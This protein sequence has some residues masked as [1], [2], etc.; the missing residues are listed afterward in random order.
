MRLSL[1]F[2]GLSLC[3][4]GFAAQCSSYTIS[5]CANDCACQ[6]VSCCCGTGC[7]RPSGVVQYNQCVPANS[8]YEQWTGCPASN[9]CATNSGL[10]RTITPCVVPT[11]SPTPSPA[12]GTPDIPFGTTFPMIGTQ[13]L[14]H[15]TWQSNV[16]MGTTMQFNPGA[17][18]GYTDSYSVPSWNVNSGN[19]GYTD[20][21]GNVVTPAPTPADATGSPCF[22]I[23]QPC[24]TGFY[25]KLNTGYNVQQ[26]GTCQRQAADTWTGG[27]GLFTDSSYYTG[28][29]HPP[30]ILD[31]DHNGAGSNSGSGYGGYYGSS[32]YG[33]GYPA[34]PNGPQSCAPLP[35]GAPVCGYKSVAG[36]C[37]CD[38]DCAKT[39]DCCSDYAQYCGVLSN[40]YTG[41]SAPSTPAYSPP[42][43]NYGSSTPAYSPPATN[44]GSSTPA[45]SPPATSSV[46]ASCG[47]VNQ[48]SGACGSS[49]PLTGLNGQTCYCDN[50][51]SQTGDC[52]CAPGQS[53]C[54]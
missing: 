23:S 21:S 7:D 29:T 12:A 2:I 14:S 20:G 40:Q 30:L 26:K 17:F 27:A 53:K 45:Y 31:P 16:Y 11:P 35:T 38:T 42:A 43:T 5:Q 50:Q 34:G 44:Y 48:C 10:V 25:C 37:F 36:S 13:A 8:P 54:F 32:G 47:A 1:G 18:W 46:G 28:L 22:A 9:S 4:T 52:C 49:A 19:G 24:P 39:G 33:N 15:N 41:Y 51:C 3:A 6:R